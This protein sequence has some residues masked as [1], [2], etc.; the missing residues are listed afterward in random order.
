MQIR[1]SSSNATAPLKVSHSHL[2]QLRARKLLPGGQV[3]ELVSD[4]KN[5]KIQQ[6]TVDNNHTGAR[7]IKQVI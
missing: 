6:A 2:D 5:S 1:N 7:R 4:S 3:I